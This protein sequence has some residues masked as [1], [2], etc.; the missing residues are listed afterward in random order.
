MHPAWGTFLA[1]AFLSAQKGQRAFPAKS[2]DLQE[3][4]AWT[5]QITGHACAMPGHSSALLPTP[6]PAARVSWPAPTLRCQHLPP[7]RMAS[8]LKGTCSQRRAISVTVLIHLSFMGG[9][10]TVGVTTAPVCYSMLSKRHKE[11]V[12]TSFLWC[13]DLVSCM[14]MSWAPKLQA[15]VLTGVWNTTWKTC[16][17]LQ[18]SGFCS[19]HLRHSRWYRE[20]HLC[21]CRNVSD[22]HRPAELSCC[23]E[24]ADLCGAAPVASSQTLLKP[25][26]LITS[27]LRLQT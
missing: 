11:Q 3:L 15:F 14:Y 25:P 7:F 17:S 23:T 20:Q 10:R 2:V 4:T 26:L 13:P 19:S 12:W 21:L 24:G 9:N 8:S 1:P 27:S 5:P 6:S 16:D 18:D 22:A